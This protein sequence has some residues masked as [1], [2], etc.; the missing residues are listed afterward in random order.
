MLLIGQLYLY[1]CVAYEAKAYL[2]TGAQIERLTVAFRRPSR[3]D[4]KISDVVK[5]PE[6]SSIKVFKLDEEEAARS[7]DAFLAEWAAMPKA[8]SSGQRSSPR[9][10]TGR[11]PRPSWLLCDVACGQF[12]CPHA[13]IL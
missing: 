12:S 9:K 3:T 4:I 8:G 11:G 5:L 13:T 7:R 10:G 1:T 6:L 2:S